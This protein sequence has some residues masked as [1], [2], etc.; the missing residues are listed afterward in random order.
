MM[1]FSIRKITVTPL[2]VRLLLV[3]GCFGMCFDVFSYLKLIMLC[4]CGK[5]YAGHYV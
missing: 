5:L 4:F 3:L 2:S 1:I